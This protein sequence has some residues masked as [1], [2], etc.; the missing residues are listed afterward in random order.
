MELCV[1]IFD[2]NT[3]SQLLNNA[4]SRANCIRNLIDL[5]KQGGGD[6]V[7]IDFENVPSSLRNPITQFMKEL[8]SAFW[9]EKMTTSMAIYPRT[10]AAF[11]LKSLYNYTDRLFAMGYNYHWESGPKAGG[12]APYP[13]IVYSINQLVKEM[14]KKDKLI[15]GLPYY[16]IEWPTETD[17]P[18]SK[19][20]GKGTAYTFGYIKEQKLPRYQRR[21]DN[22]CKC[23][24][25]AF[26]DEKGW[27]QGWYDDDESL[28]LKF[29]YIKSYGLLGTGMWA[30]EFDRGLLWGEIERYLRN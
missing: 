16:G 22:D 28:R 1:P 18:G 20:T 23:P 6:G 14:E 2:S 4:Q 21:W 10:H 17:A 7:N 15:F 26:K 25:Y 3:L 24:W 11:D 29:D 13:S 5:V 27:R 12:V 9:K 8:S 30:L 19:T